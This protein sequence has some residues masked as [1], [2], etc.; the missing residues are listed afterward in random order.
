MRADGTEHHEFMIN[1]PQVRLNDLARE[2]ELPEHGKFWRS[3][4]VYHFS[5]YE[6]RFET[7]R[8]LGFATESVLREFGY[9]DRQ[10]DEL[11]EKGV[12]TAVGHGLPA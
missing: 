1:D 8:P 5:E 10:I 9:S 3:A 7:P 4:P 12:T 6:T 11:N 2:D